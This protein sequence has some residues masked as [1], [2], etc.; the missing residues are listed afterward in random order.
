MEG[1]FLR[2]KLG[3][4]LLLLICGIFFIGGY[5][6]LNIVDPSADGGMII[7]LILGIIEC[8]SVIP[9]WMFNLGA[10]VRVDEETIKAK[11]NWFGTIECSLSDVVYATARINSLIIHLNDGNIHTINGISNA[12]H[13]ASYLR[14]NMSFESSEQPEVLHKK[15]D[16]LRADKK[17]GLIRVVI[18]IAAMFI[19]IFLAVFLTG[20]RDIDEFNRVDWI[21]FSVMCVIEIAILA[22]VFCF[23]VKAGRNNEPIE[24]LEYTFRRRVIETEALLP[25]NMIKVLADDDYACRVTVY[26]YPNDGSVY[27]T[28]QAIAWPMLVKV[29]TSEIFESI[30]LCAD[31]L[32]GLIDI[33]KC[34]K[35]E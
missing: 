27:Y 13:L 28:V 29:Y 35:A 5:I 30:D 33:T 9:I 1:I 34:V 8:L 12:S 31:E 17:K 32:E 20:G 25:G 4:V 24:K 26:G 11:Y 16:E 7:L 14:R 18:G 15:I 2:K 6:F 23:A 19:N 10:F 3:F 21:I 22:V